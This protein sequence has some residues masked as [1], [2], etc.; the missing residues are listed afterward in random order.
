MKKKFT[1]QA[2]FFGLKL[3]AL[4]F[5]LLLFSGQSWGQTLLLN[6]NFDYT[7]GTLLTANGWNIT[8]TTATPNVAVSIASIA[9]S[10][11]LSS[12]IGNEV[13][14]ATSGQDVNKT[15][16]AQTS[17]TVYAS[18]LV[19]ISSASTTG[20]YFFHLGATTISTIFH[21]RV[22][23][24][25]DASNNL[26]FGISRAGAIAT[27]IFTPFTYSLNTTYLLVLRYSIVSGATND[28]AAIYI[29]PALNA[30]EPATGW[31]TSTD[32]PADLAN[33]GSVALRQGSASNAAAIKLDGIRVATTWDDIVGSSSII[34]PTLVADTINNNVDNNIDISF[35]EDAIWRAAVT[36]VKLGGTTLT[37]ATD[38]L[39]TAGNLQLLPSGGNPLL[40]TA[41]SKTISV[42]AFGYSPANLIQL[43]NAGAPTANSTATINSPLAIN[44]TSIITCTAKDQY[45]NPV[46]GYTFKYDALLTNNN[47]TTA[48]TYTVDGAAISTTTNDIGILATTNA[49]GLATFTVLLPS[50]ID[51]NDGISIQLQLSNGTTNI[52][53]EFSF[54]QL[55]SQTITFDPLSDKTY[56]DADFNLIATSTSGLNVGFVSSNTSVASI[57]GTTLTILKNGTT[58]ITASQ[59]GNATYNPAA[60]VIRT[61]TVNQ[62]ALTIPDAVAQ[63]KVY[64]T[65][66]I[67]IITGS[68]T[69]IVGTDT[70]TLVGNGVF[71]DSNVANA[72]PVTSACTLAGPQASRYTLVQPTGLSADITQAS[73]TIIFAAIPAKTTIDAD[74]SPGATSASSAVNP[75][76]YTSSDLSVATIVADKIHIVGVGTSV[77]TASQAGSLNYTA[78]AD[79]QQTLTVSPGP[80]V[81]WQFGIPAALGTE[82]TYNATTNHNDL[83]TSVLSRGSGIAPTALARGFSANFWNAGATKDT[84]VSTNEYYQFVIN[85]KT[86][87]AVSL[88][89]LN[90]TLRR[91]STAPNAYIWKYSLDGTTFTEIGTD[92]ISFTSTA[93][94]VPQAQIDL[95]GIAAL[96]NVTNTTTITFRLY[97]WGGTSLTSTFAFARY[98]AGNTTNCLAIGGTVLPSGN[99]VPTLTTQ[100][101]TS[102]TD[103]SATGNGNITATGGINPTL[104]GFC[105]DIASNADPDVSDSK[106]EETGSFSIGAFTGSIS[107]LSAATQ[108]K[109]KAFASN[110]IGVAYGDVVVFTTLSAEPL[111]H[112]VSFAAVATSQ[113]Q[114]DLSF[115]AA[116]TITNATAYLILQKT[117]AAPSGTPIDAN[118]Y[119]V[120]NTIGDATVAAVITNTADI[121]KV[122]TGLAAGT[123]YY[124]TI[125]PYNW[126]GV[127]AISHNYKTDAIVPLTDAITYSALNTTSE[128]SGPAL[129]SQPNPVL[130]SSL[131]TTEAAAIRVFDM[132]VWDYS[133]DA[134]PTKIT[135]LTIKAGTANTANWIN[136]IQ[137]I[138]LSTNAGV[139]FVNIGIPVISA[140]SIV[141]PVTSGD[142]NIPDNDALTLSFYVY[143]KNTAL[144]DN[145][146]LEFKVDNTAASHGFIADATGSTFLPTFTTAPVS[147]QILIDVV[148]T[149]LMFIQ[150]PANVGIAVNIT[151]AVTLRAVDANGNYDLDYNTAVSMNATGALLNAAPVIATPMNGMAIFSTLSFNTAASGVT[152][153]ATS[154]L[155]TG[156]SSSSFDVLLL[157]AAGDIVINQFSPDYSGASNEYIEL[158]NRT[159]K[160]FDLSLFKIEYKSSTGGTSSSG[161]SLSGSIGPYQYWL[162][163]PDAIITVGQTL[164]LTRDG[165]I[166]SG[167]AAA[168]GQLAL[169]LKNS[170]NTII[171]GL[172]Y[173]T[174]TSNTL[175][176]A[177]A[178]STPPADGGLL[179]SIEGIDKDSNSIDF[180]SVTQAIIYLRNH[181]SVCIPA[182]YTL[183]LT[184]YPADVVISGTSPYITLSGNTTINGKLRILA[185]NLTISS[186]Q[187][188][189]V[190]GTLTN[191]VGNSGLVIKSDPTGTASLLHTTAAVNASVE[192][193]IPHMFADEFHMLSS[194]VTAQAI[195]PEFNELDAF[196]VW[197]E[198]TAN[199]IEYANASPAFVAANGG[200][201]L[202]PGKGYAVSYPNQTIKDYAGILNQGSIS[203]P[204]AFTP[205]S[206]YEGWNFVGNPYP[207]SINWDA[208]TGW[209]RNE[210]EDAGGGDNAMWVWNA[211]LGAYGAYTFTAGGTN[212]VSNYIP[213]SQGYWVKAISAGTLAM[214]NDVREHSSQSYLKS[215]SVSDRLRLKVS[216]TANTYCDEIIVKF[217]NASNQLGAEKM[218]SMY[219]TAPNLYSTKMN[220]NWTINNLTSIAQNAVVPLGFKAGADGNYTMHASEL[221]SFSTT[222]YVY[223]KDLFTNNLSDLNQHADYTFAA[224]ATDIADRFQLIFTLSPLKISDNLIQNSAIYSYEN[225]IF[226]AANENIQK[227]TIYNTLGQLIKTLENKTAKIAVDMNGNASGY[228]I[229]KVVTNKNVYSEKVLIK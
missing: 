37:P 5:A 45:N 125:Y 14:L 104:R 18:C 131:H 222:T 51:G 140:T 113:T 195:A 191:T 123:H 50:I 141:I 159:D 33:I 111:S 61:L 127:N 183:P 165:A 17:G 216:G 178:A 193:F 108:Y 186:N 85:P 132:D 29:N 90:A 210:L 2:H 30:A 60:N 110:A 162:L 1:Q 71:A 185:G 57:S 96:Q 24:K 170:P 12:G 28:I 175:G 75:I 200:T 16:T 103:N 224:S 206:T 77:I 99:L 188:L 184:T 121:S 220:K 137:G 25:K 48:E 139:S 7:S 21:G 128:V 129:I 135:Q 211:G 66:K 70:V 171:D 173:G 144:T 27:A 80:I 3:T 177:T 84:A 192:R 133:G 214:T 182:N 88:S 179:R 101:V 59:A 83:D 223:L 6:E 52:G 62:K 126:D 138:K 204:L 102:I 196:Y 9:Y 79:V 23:V 78:A 98:A 169:R 44:S 58:D 229:V 10:G 109:V 67:A 81:A 205:A 43:I 174:V 42:E 134:Q 163:S 74:F 124:F 31:T 32:A 89:S 112:A 4:L 217:G 228:Y 114:I 55:A 93:D 154:G 36:A 209:T 213:I 76:T 221:N 146:I 168:A 164:S 202:V 153:D 218:F 148:A 227:I 15:F 150:Q 194:A 68:L 147:N 149:K 11:Y 155:L 212:G 130:L 207:S 64:N 13:S 117:D 215:T 40:T 187:N 197:N 226:V 152:L 107:G 49:S 73:Q 166:N 100:A 95:T 92:S 181:N 47:S 72:I 87:Y 69:G 119:A 156:I 26:A 19:N 201:N 180:S 122:I 91:T 105:W 56:G 167:F 8:G 46:A 142:L 189:T 160:T 199:W 136:T 20:D 22:F 34:T 86:T 54:S 219:A 106:V 82:V 115:S 158:V 120:G 63:N 53:T 38:F 65:T 118:A 35:T 176:E 143:L 94:G 97:A 172:A 116:S 161:G 225:T 41:G 157:P 39:L 151:P 203:I 208:V 145:S 190:L 198:P